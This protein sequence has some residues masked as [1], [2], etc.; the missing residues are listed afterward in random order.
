M[1]LPGSMAHRQVRRAARRGRAARGLVLPPGARASTQQGR[2]GWPA[3]RVRAAPPTRS[4]GR[5]TAGR[6]CCCRRPRPPARARGVGGPRPCRCCLVRRPSRGQRGRPPRRR[7]RRFGTA[8]GPSRACADRGARGPPS[9]RGR[10]RGAAPLVRRSSPKVRRPGRA[11]IARICARGPRRATG[12][13]RRRSAGG[14]PGRDCT[15]TGRAAPAGNHR[16][17]RRGPRTG[18]ARRAGWR[19]PAA[20][21]GLSPG[22]TRGCGRGRFRRRPEVRPRTSVPGPPRH[23]PGNS[24]GWP[25]AARGWRPA[26]PGAARARGAAPRVRVRTRPAP[27]G[28]AR[29]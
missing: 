26:P 18:R 20:S 12:P 5:S 27:P 3:H 13:A 21:D 6:P 9:S 15:A 10:S 29:P 25:A 11:A 28:P 19:G 22:S 14:R 1:R 2:P 7:R 8:D 23:R 24:L 17:P 4:P 16:R